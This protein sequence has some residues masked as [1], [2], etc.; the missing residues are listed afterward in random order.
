MTWFPTMAIYKGTVNDPMAFLPRKGHTSLT[1]GSSSVFSPWASPRLAAAAFV[2]FGS[3]LSLLDGMLDIGFV[4]HSHIWCAFSYSIL[5]DLSA[6]S[7][8]VVD[9]SLTLSQWITSIRVNSQ[10]PVRCSPW[11]LCLTS[12]AV[13]VGA[14]DFNTSGACLN[15][16]HTCV[17]LTD[18]TF[19]F[20]ICWFS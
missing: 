16:V 15:I 8:T 9:S 4:V 19:R 14:Y 13:G 1:T 7:A 11:M 2:I 12:L 5:F 3:L 18:Q 17:R 10:H 20:W 6:H